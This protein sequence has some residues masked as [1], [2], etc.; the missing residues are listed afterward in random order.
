MKRGEE[1]SLMFPVRDLWERSERSTGP[2]LWLD[3]GGGMEVGIL[4]G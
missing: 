4:D 2:V 3:M 1:E